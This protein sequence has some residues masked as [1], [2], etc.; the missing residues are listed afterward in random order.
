MLGGSALAQHIHL[1]VLVWAPVKGSCLWGARLDW[2]VGDVIPWGQGL[3]RRGQLFRAEAPWE[4][5]RWREQVR[6]NSDLL[7][8]IVPPPRGAT[9]GLGC[10]CAHLGVFHAGS[11]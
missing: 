5:G 9:K 10:S 4:E 1:L 6:G 11:Q 3:G 8:G 2:E 7:K